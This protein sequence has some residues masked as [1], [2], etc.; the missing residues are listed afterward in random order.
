MLRLGLGKALRMLRKGEMCE[1]RVE[2]DLK[3]HAVDL[4]SLFGVLEKEI[5]IFDYFEMTF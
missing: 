5:K 2:R 4:C 1:T 3:R